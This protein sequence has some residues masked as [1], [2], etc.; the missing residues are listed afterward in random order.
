MNG[1][2]ILVGSTNS[3]SSDVDVF[4]GGAGQD[5]FVIGT[6][7]KNF[8]SGPGYA[9]L[10]DYKSGV[11]YIQLHSETGVQVRNEFFTRGT[12]GRGDTSVM[13]TIIYDNNNNTMAVIPDQ[14]FTLSQLQAG[15]HLFLL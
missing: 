12:V 2:D 6:R 9:V 7:V 4:K 3:G 15:D 5:L 14:S 1:S 13:D 8:Y 10:E 11:D